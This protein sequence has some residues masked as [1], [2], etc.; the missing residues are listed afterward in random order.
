MKSEYLR[1]A[2]HLRSLGRVY[3]RGTNKSKG[4]KARITL[5]QSA[6]VVEQVKDPALSLL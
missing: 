3:R 1:D 2:S 5:A 6:L 4:A